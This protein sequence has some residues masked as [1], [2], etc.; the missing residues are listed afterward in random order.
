MFE[1]ALIETIRKK[2]PKR[3]LLTLPLAIAVHAL[4]LGV[5]VVAQ[6]WA[7]EELPEPTIQVSF[8][9]APPP[10]PP[11]PAPPPKA[12]PAPK[13]PPVVIKAPEVQPMEIPQE[14]PK[15]SNNGAVG[16]EGGV[17][18]G[19]E[20]GEAGGVVGGIPGGVPGPTPVPEPEQEAPIRIGG[21]VIAPVRVKVV[22]PV[23]SEIARKARVQGPVILEAI[24]DKQGNV[25]DVRV[26]RGLPMGLSQAAAEA[27]RKW[28]YQPATMFGKPV[29]VYL[30]VTVQFTLQ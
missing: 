7:V 21:P 20:G 23:Y 28:K 12:A 5:V 22:N 15:P 10:P 1:D 19:I 13:A 9:Q 4:V 8:Y 29:S 24:I 16:V 25:T 11:P 17:E 30:T 2:Q 27:V 3:K 26:L 6:L 18:G 14:I